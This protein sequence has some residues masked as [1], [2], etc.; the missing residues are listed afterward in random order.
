[1]HISR[2]IFAL[3]TCLFAVLTIP[4]EAQTKFNRSIVPNFWDV[5]SPLEKP[6]NLKITRLRFLTTTDF[7]PFNFIDRKKRLSGFHIDLAQQI[8]TELKILRLC[9]IQAIPWAELESAIAKGDGE[10]IIAGLEL[11]KEN[12]KLFEFSR[13]FLQIPARFVAKKN[14]GLDEPM[15]QTLYQRKTGVVKSSAH[16]QYFSSVFSNRNS[17]EFDSLAEA[18]QAMIDN[19]IDTV[20]A[21]AVSLAFWL[22]S[23]NANKC[24]EF[25]GGPYLSREYFGNGLTIAV[26]KGNPDLVSAINYAL[27]RINDKGIFAELYLRY[28]PISLY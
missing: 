11:N 8:C 2:S 21:D 3:F 27:R 16:A 7:P 15:A 25:V 26:A 22:S 9:Q 10:A 13:P 6:Q 23:K 28:F 4:A 18:K 1:M 17:I 12:S 24:C 5:D 19:K 20:F 14:S